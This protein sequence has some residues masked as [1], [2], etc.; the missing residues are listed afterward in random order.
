MN[1]KRANTI[2]G[3][4]TPKVLLW[5]SIVSMIMLFAGLTS[6]YIVRQ[7]EGNWLIFELPGTFKTSTLFIVLSSISMY[8][9]LRATKKDNNSMN[10]AYLLT[11]LAL[12]VGF[13]Y[14]QFL[15][16]S[17]LVDQGVY[18]VGN[19]SGSFLYVITG[20]HLAHLAGGLICLLVVISK[21]IFGKYN[22]NN[23]LG[24]SLTATYWHFL[25]I[26]WVYLFVFLSLM[27]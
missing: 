3:I 11:T 21:S 15:G 22:S 6:G 2:T 10:I 19:P 14:T 24:L 26:L 18:Y 27:R 5:I 13:C 8:L 12:G 20:L 1:A 23:Y 25:G 4:P 7:A 9:S 17:T 16:W